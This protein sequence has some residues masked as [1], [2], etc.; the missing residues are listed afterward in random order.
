MGRNF[1]GGADQDNNGHGTHC[2]GTVA[3][4]TFGVAKG[5]TVIG[6]KVLGDAGSGSYDGIISGIEW[7]V[8]EAKRT[9][10]RGIGNMSLGGGRNAALNDAVN[11]AAG[12]GLL[13]SNAAGNCAIPG[14]PMFG[15]ACQTSPASAEDGICVGSTELASQAGTQVDA[16]SGFSNWGACVDVFAPGSGID[17][18]YAGGDS[19]YAT[20]SGTSMAAPHVCGVGAVVLQ[21]HPTYTAAQ[22]SAEIVRTA[23][24]GLLSGDIGAGSP[25]KM[26]HIAC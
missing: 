17:S 1:A 10:R 3:G 2:A 15:D 24:D 7:S 9:G 6:V 4:K 20:L 11:A 14:L 13:F 19:A 22:V 25:N 16:K 26:L 23:M 18:A 21:E 5:A 8:E 12:E